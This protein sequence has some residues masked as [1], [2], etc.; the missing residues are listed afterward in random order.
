[1]DKLYQ[2]IVKKEGKVDVI[3]AHS[4]FWGGIAGAFISKKYNIF[5]MTFRLLH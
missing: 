4:V 5:F 1:M 3:H 2:E